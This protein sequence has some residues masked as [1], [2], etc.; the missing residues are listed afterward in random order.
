M[1]TS[2]LKELWHHFDNNEKFTSYWR[3]LY[4]PKGTKLNAMSTSQYSSSV[5]HLTWAPRGRPY[6]A[7][8][9]SVSEHGAS[10][11]VFTLYIYIRLNIHS[12]SRLQA[13]VG[14]LTDVVDRRVGYIIYV[15]KSLLRFYSDGHVLVRPSVTQVHHS[16]QARMSS[17]E[18]SLQL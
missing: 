18:L 16:T 11:T 12:L 14:R 7:D 1:M 3:Q 10:L 6:G 17:W 13:H 9:R 5:M 15:T 4:L 2:L 8:V